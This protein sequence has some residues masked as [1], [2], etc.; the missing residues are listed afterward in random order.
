MKHFTPIAMLLLLVSYASAEEKAEKTPL[1]KHP[2]LVSMLASNN[3]LRASRGMAAHRMSI[4][5]TKAA[6]DHAWYMA[7]TGNFSHQSNGGPMGRARRYGYTGLVRE[8]I[9]SG[10]IG[11]AEA[12]SSWKASG[13]HWANIVS[14]TSE[15]GFGYAIAPDG[16]TYWV[17]MYGP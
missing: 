5:L 10:Q 16:T 7:R 17:A 8:N 9:A 6:Q 15:A 3:A 14:G 4:A 11:V 1:H 2:T 12:F 13:G